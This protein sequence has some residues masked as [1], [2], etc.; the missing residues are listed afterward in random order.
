MI[1]D[2]LLSLELHVLTSM[3]LQVCGDLLQSNS[4]PYAVLLFAATTL[5]NKIRKQL[6]T[7]PQDAWPGLR[8]TLANCINTHSISHQPVSTQLSIA[9]SALILRWP[10]WEDVLPYLGDMLRYLQA[11][12]SFAH[13]L[14]TQVDM[15][16][17]H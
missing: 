1:L 7:L 13:R 14:F 17:T 6:H 4:Q 3:C 10:Q 8:D 11:P 9:M 16:D 5:R 15:Q 12:V 2:I